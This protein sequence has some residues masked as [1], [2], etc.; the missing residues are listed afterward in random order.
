MNKTRGRNDQKCSE[1]NFTCG[2]GIKKVLLR[3]AWSVTR[4][5]AKQSR[6]RRGG[7]FGALLKTFFKAIINYV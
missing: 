6:A 3:N 2:G 1:Y 7:G 5:T 4:V